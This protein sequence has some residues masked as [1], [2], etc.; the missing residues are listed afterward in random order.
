MTKTE[1]SELL[2]SLDIPVNEGFTPKIKN[3]DYPRIVYWDYI[4]ED[5]TSSGE[6]YCDKL[7]Y[8]ISFYSLTPA[9][10]KLIELRNK[11]RNIGIRPQIFHEYI[12]EDRIIHSYM[13]IEVLDG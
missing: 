2:H 8:Q 9:H 3:M 5:A 7:T 13:A 12:E 10:E 6:T 4:W 1:L 11:L